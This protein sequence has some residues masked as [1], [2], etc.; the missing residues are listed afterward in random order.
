MH[1]TRRASA[2]VHPEVA[3]MMSRRSSGSAKDRPALL[4]GP[5]LRVV[6]CV[7]GFETMNSVCVCWLAA[8]MV[9]SIPRGTER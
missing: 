4:I 5:A 1:P 6:K 3:A 8:W 2:Y 9:G 7:Y